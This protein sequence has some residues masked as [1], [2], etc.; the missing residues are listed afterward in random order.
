MK[1][2]KIHF[3]KF[4]AFRSY[5]R[6]YRKS[7]YIPYDN[8]MFGLYIDKSSISEEKFV[9]K[10]H[11]GFTDWRFHLRN[12]SNY[13][14]IIHLNINKD[15]RNRGYAEWL[16]NYVINNTTE[17]RINEIVLNCGARNYPALI[18]F[19]KHGF[20]VDNSL[21]SNYILHYPGYELLIKKLN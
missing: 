20:V 12:N 4:G 6:N 19:S 7:D 14:E 17:N 13:C 2:S 3:N 18:F 16:L 9:T 11:I 5:L 8:K 15:H 10:T 21:K 1:M